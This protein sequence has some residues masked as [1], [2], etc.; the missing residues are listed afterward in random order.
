MERAVLE[1]SPTPR[2]P[3][4]GG[5]Y[6]QVGEMNDAVIATLEIGGE[7]RQT[8]REALEEAVVEA[9]NPRLGGADDMAALVIG[10]GH[11]MKVGDDIDQAEAGYEVALHRARQQD[12]EAAG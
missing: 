8:A 1:S 7:R 10:A 4:L 2:Q 12:I 6:L 9:A 3:E 11:D 5:K